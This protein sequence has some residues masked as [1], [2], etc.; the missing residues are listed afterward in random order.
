M[1]MCKDTEKNRVKLIRKV[2]SMK[3]GVR[4]IEHNPNFTEIILNC[5]N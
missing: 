3:I 4:S 5:E 1:N 2:G